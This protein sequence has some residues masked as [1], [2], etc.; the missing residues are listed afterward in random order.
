VS[1]AL[2]GDIVKLLNDTDARGTVPPRDAITLNVHPR[3][4]DI[5]VN[6][7]WFLS[8][9]MSL[10][11]V[12][13]GTL[14]LQWL[15]AFRSR[16]LKQKR[17][18]DA[19]ALRQLRFEGLMGWGIPL[20]PGFLLLAVQISLVLFGLGL[21]Q[22]LWSVNTRVAIPVVLV[23]S[24]T[25]LLLTI[26]AVMPLLQS[27]IGWIFPST[28]IIPQCPYKSPLAWIFH[29]FCLLLPIIVSL[30]FYLHSRPKSSEK[31]KVHT[32]CSHSWLERLSGWCLDQIDILIDYTWQA[33][34]DLWRRQRECRGPQQSKS[35]SKYSY[36]LVQGLASAMGKLVFQPHAVH[37]I[38]TC[39]QDFHGTSAEEETFEDLF[40]KST[41]VVKQAL[42]EY[43][44]IVK[45]VVEDRS[46]P[47]M[48]SFHKES[49]RRDFLNAFALQSFV[50]Q[51]SKLHRAL[52]PHRVELYIRIKTSSQHFDALNREGQYIGTSIECPIRDTRD[53]QAL[54][55]G[56]FSHSLF[57]R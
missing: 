19:L 15:S 38:H 27:V 16:E 40:G 34:D 10:S 25:A 28:L 44:A 8:M 9:I 26:T 39:L 12:V 18:I 7:L 14:C 6:Q 46:R 1:T 45:E 31:R 21:M 3:D 36:Y 50:T 5:V 33:F 35:K 11:A 20:V 41:P 23:G 17:Y 55:A 4:S 2:L 51:N 24:T 53:A 42:S 29:R 48:S 32:P 30:P 49:L 52:L 43:S 22:L 56:T 54:S 37:I 13:V 57:T 47:R